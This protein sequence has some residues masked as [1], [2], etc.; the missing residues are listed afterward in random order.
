MTGGC[1]IVTAISYSVTKTSESFVAATQTTWQVSVSKGWIDSRA[2]CE[3]TSSPQSWTWPRRIAPQA[4]SAAPRGDGTTCSTPTV[5]LKP[6]IGA[7][8]RHTP[9]PS[10]RKARIGIPDPSSLMS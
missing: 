5:A 7:H 6:F 4:R 8:L 1:A 2:Q 3:R 9:G 10:I